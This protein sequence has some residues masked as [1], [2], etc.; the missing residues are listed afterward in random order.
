MFCNSMGRNCMLYLVII[1]PPS[2]TKIGYLVTSFWYCTKLCH[3]R[4]LKINKSEKK[5]KK[6]KKRSLQ[7]CLFLIKNEVY[8]FEFDILPAVLRK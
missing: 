5:K 7:V 3:K 2:R 1:L 8:Y 4:R 6:K